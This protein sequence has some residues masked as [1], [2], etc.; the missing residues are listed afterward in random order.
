M[1]EIIL[2]DSVVIENRM[3]KELGDIDSLA[4]S[5][6]ENGLINPITLSLDINHRPMLIAGERRLTALKKLGVTELVHN[7]HFKWRTEV[8]SDEYRR[9]AVELEEN[10]RR[11]AL[12][13]SEE[14]AAKQK[15]LEIYQN[16]Y[17][18]PSS[19]AIT[20]Q[21]RVGLKP[22][23]FGVRKLS[24]MIGES[25]TQ[26]SEDLTLAALVAKIPILAN[27]PTKEA[28][29]R[30]IDIAMKILGGKQVT[31]VAQPLV[32]KIIITC[33]S[34]LHQTLLLEQLRSQNIDCKP[35]VA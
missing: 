10:I 29:R 13:W 3:R 8:Y 23:G 4:K 5:I 32:Y 2:I 26:T 11:K 12:T 20:R 25:A 27:E 22:Q 19:G 24:E 7:E 17:G 28:A 16:I 30:K 15:L 9:N 14:I 34:E 21:E 18:P 1:S 6:E 31:P 33:T 35:I